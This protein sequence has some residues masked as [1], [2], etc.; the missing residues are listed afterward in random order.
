MEDAGF[1]KYSGDANVIA[2]TVSSW[3][4][5]PDMLERMQ[6]AALDAARPQATVDIARDIGAM[7]FDEKERQRQ[8]SGASL[9]ASS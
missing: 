2:D 6:Q 1:G 9:S 4:G 7:L 8:G 5:S 3:L